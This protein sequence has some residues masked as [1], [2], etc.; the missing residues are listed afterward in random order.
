M[1]KDMGE[2]IVCYKYSE[3]VCDQCST[4][5]FISLTLYIRY[6]DFLKEVVQN[7]LDL[8]A[9]AD[10]IDQHAFKRSSKTREATILKDRMFENDDHCLISSTFFTKLKLQLRARR[11]LLG[12]P[13]KCDLP[14]YLHCSEELDPTNY[15][16]CV[17]YPFSYDL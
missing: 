17:G 12:C 3:C 10:K 2:S 5:Y 11:R 8:T 6:G 14:L 9:I 15:I 1:K 4:K 7:Q 13:Q 16:L